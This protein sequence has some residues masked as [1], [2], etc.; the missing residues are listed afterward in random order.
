MIKTLA[1]DIVKDLPVEFNKQALQPYFDLVFEQAQLDERIVWFKNL[2]TIS[3]TSLG[4]AHCIQHD[5]VSRSA[6]Q[7]G[8]SQMAKDRILPLGY[9]GVIGCWSGLKRSDTLAMDGMQISGMKRWITNIDQARYVTGQVMQG[10]KKLVFFVDL[11]E[12]PHK[13]GHNNFQPIGMELARPGDLILDTQTL[14]E[15]NILGIANTQQFFQQD[16]LASYCWVTNHFGITKQLFLDIKNY[17]IDNHCGAE[18]EIKKLEMDICSLQMQW[19]DNL[20]TLSNIQ[21]TDDF[22]NKRNVQ[23]AFGKKTLIKV[24]QLILEIGVSYWADAAAPYSQR[25]RDAVTYCSHQYPLY[26][27]GQTHYMLDLDGSRDHPAEYY[28][29]KT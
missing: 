1:A 11:L 29:N 15:H 2:L 23:Y 5:M 25:F 26:R 28:A 22:W 8:S 20:A 19:Q 3:Q 10:D 12:T 21:T 13:I 27:F 17:E 16:N 7:Q 6:I 9:D 4:L 18:F 14:S 24:I